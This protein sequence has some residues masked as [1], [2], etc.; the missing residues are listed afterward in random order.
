MAARNSEHSDPECKEL[1]PQ[2]IS[3][4]IEALCD[5][6][7]DPP[8]RHV[9]MELL[10]L[11]KQAAEKQSRFSS[12]IKS[13]PFLFVTVFL[14]VALVA[15]VAIIVYIDPH[16]GEAKSIDL[17]QAFDSATQTIIVIGAAALFLWTLEDRRKR[18]NVIENISALR[19]IAH[20]I[21]EQ[22]LTKDPWTILRDTSPTPG[23]PQCDKNHKKLYYFLLDCT[24]LLSLVGKTGFLYVEEFHDAQAVS[25]VNDLESLTADLSLLIWQKILL[26]EEIAQDR[27]TAWTHAEPIM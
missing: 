16:L 11:S 10:C 23:S 4:S 15:I 27:A 22:Q 1:D 25:A 20:R 17:I 12:W 2:E 14:L 8:L 6:I 26:L 24:E 13:L 7:D 9:S 21:D 3:R 18:H 19:Q 5:R